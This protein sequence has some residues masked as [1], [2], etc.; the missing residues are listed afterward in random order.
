MARPRKPDGRRVHENVMLSEAE[1]AVIDAARG[2]VKRGPWIRQAA[3]DA[4][5]REPAA[6]SISGVRVGL[7]V[8]PRQ[9]PGT[10]SVISPGEEVTQVRSFSL[11]PKPEPEE[12]PHP[13]ARILRGLCNACGRYV[14][15]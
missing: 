9:P 3:L 1:A 15:S 2:D 5:R 13:R 4:A 7:T 10:V 12:C 11:A 8:D 14:G 6:V